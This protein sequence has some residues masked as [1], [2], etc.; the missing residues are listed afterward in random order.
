MRL[1]QTDKENKR[2]VVLTWIRALVLIL[3]AAAIASFVTTT[4]V[5]D[6]FENDL[7][8]QNDAFQQEIITTQEESREEVFIA[9]VN[10][11]RRNNI[12]KAYLIRNSRETHGLGIRATRRVFPILNCA[13]TVGEGENIAL[14]SEVQQRYIR[15][16]VDQQLLPQVRDG[17]IVGK[18]RVEG[19]GEINGYPGTDSEG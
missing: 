16:V 19:A 10:A 11:C 15:I 18:E 1:F 8:Q 2:Y 7:Q 14:D 4:V 12:V 3:T 17:K 6:H 5:D 13:A 9:E